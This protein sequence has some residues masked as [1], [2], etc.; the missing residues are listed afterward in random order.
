[1]Q[2]KVENSSF[3]F[4][5]ISYSR[6]MDDYVRFTGVMKLPSCKL[7]GFMLTLNLTLQYLTHPYI[8]IS[9]RKEINIMRQLD[10]PHI[11]RLFEVIDTPSNVYVVMEYMSSGEMFY[12]LTENGKLHE[13]EARRLFQ[14]V[15][16]STHNLYPKISRTLMI[17]LMQRFETDSF[18]C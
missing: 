7:L 18:R 10:H 2:K 3:F 8:E 1:M 11:V 12:Y 9:V 6:Q 17:C 14:Q 13:D 15:L 4:S 5:G 16:L